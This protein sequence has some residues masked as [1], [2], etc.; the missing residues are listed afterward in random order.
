M[1]FIA[2]VIVFSVV[3]VVALYFG[4]KNAEEGWEDKYHK[5]RHP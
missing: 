4:F 5:G 2:G 3:L 1:W